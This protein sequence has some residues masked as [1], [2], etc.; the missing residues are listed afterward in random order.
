MRF[1]HTADWHVGKTLKGR[2]RLEEQTAVLKEIVTLAI[3]HEV[4]AVLVAGD[5]YDTSSP[6]PAA[7]RLVVRTLMALA[8]R[9]IEVVAIAGNHDNPAMFEAY[10]PLMAQAGIHVRG[11]AREPHR[12]GV[13]SFTVD[14]TGERCQIALL[15]FLSQR[16]AVRAA[17]IMTNTPAENVGHYDQL[18]RDLVQELTTGF[19]PDAVRI[20]MAHLT[21][22][23]GQFGG[24]ERQAQSIF[25]YHVPASIFGTDLHYVALGH[26]H[27]RQHIP[28][29]CPVHYSGS[30]IAVDFGEQ[31]Y[32]PGVCLIEVAPGV[33]AKVTDLPIT[34]GRR[35]RTVTG[36][37]AELIADPDRYGDDLLRVV[38][39][40]PG[41]A[42]LRDE[43]VEA[44]PHTL[45][46]RIHPDH[47]ATA[48]RA[49]V[50]V[51]RP[52]RSPAELFSDYCAENGVDDPRLN[53]LF[54]QLLDE[55]TT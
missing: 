5:L 4:D 11:Q 13:H 35:L 1:L 30:P 7:Q 17:Q 47:A 9:G 45:E 2:D 31:D 48:A 12:G 20:V 29:A 49:G 8:S 3:N 16:Y 22:T 54:D 44:L 26:L 36:T 40:E 21:C 55:T 18:L 24:G 50:A 10:Q 46:V 37:V 33:P 34:S 15:P 28:A 14:S 38:V 42:G 25:E 41:R 27:R 43:I 53:A 39:T 51:D 19:E 52:Q 6:T 32:T 23:G